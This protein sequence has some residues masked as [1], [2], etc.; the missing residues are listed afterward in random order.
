[1]I[2]VLLRQNVTFCVMKIHVYVIKD[3]KCNNI[4][5]SISYIKI[6]MF[7]N[8]KSTY[9]AFFLTLYIGYSGI[10]LYILNL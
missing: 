3:N 6:S 10:N 8:E 2:C 4:L 1:M 9:G 5:Y 7:G